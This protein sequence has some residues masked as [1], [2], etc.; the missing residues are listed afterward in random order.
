MDV[1]GYIGLVIGGIFFW[2]WALAK[3]ENMGLEKVA[4]LLYKSI[5]FLP[6][7]NISLLDLFKALSLADSAHFSGENKNSIVSI[8]Q[9]REFS[10][11]ASE[12]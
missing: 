11:I 9:E 1:L 6:Q 5:P 10:H 3:K 2:A 12:L 4:R 7:E 8:L